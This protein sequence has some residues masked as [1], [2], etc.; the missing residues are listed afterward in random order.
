MWQGD[1]ECAYSS[2]SSSSCSS[3]STSSRFS[4]GSTNFL[5]CLTG[6]AKI[7]SLSDDSSLRAAGSARQYRRNARNG[8]GRAHEACWKLNPV[9]MRNMLY[10]NRDSILC[11][12]LRSSIG[13]VTGCLL[14]VVARRA[15]SFAPAARTTPVLAGKVLERAVDTREPH[16]PSLSPSTRSL[17]CYCLCIAFRSVSFLFLFV[18]S[19][20]QPTWR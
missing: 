6:L 4:T 1:V 19:Q 14:L 17:S 13:C 11:A 8:G 12:L 10:V 2:S 16:H 15:A 18:D 20:L 9:A 5:G 7:M 3:P